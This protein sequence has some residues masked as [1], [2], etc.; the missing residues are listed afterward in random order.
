MNKVR[1]DLVR[2]ALDEGKP[3][4]ADGQEVVPVRRA[5][6]AFVSVDTS[7]L[8][9]RVL[10]VFISIAGGWGMDVD[11]C[12]MKELHNSFRMNVRRAVSVDTSRGCYGGDSGNCGMDREHGVIVSI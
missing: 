9:I 5:W 8:A 1:Y 2:S 6:K 11:I 10:A 3:K 4:L 12:K 7:K